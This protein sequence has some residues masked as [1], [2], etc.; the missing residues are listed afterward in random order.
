MVL[1]PAIQ[2]DVALFHAPLADKTGNVWIGTRRELVTLAHASRTT[3]V[4]V[5]ALHPGNLLSDPALASGTLPHLYVTRV[6]LA[7]GGTWPLPF[8]GNVPGDEQAFARYAD[9]SR[10]AEAFSALLREWLDARA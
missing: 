1:V 9:A 2:P 5:E 6:A 3:F 7:P 4:T 8:A 10:G